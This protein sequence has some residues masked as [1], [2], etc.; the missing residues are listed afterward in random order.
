MTRFQ[1]RHAQPENFQMNSNQPISSKER[2][3]VL[4]I[5]DSWRRWLAVVVILLAGVVL[6]RA[7]RINHEGRILGPMPV[8]TN[9]VLFNTP[10]ADAIM[11]AL[12]IFPRDNAWN[13]DISRRPVLANSDSI[14]TNIT[15]ELLAGRR[16]LRAFYEMNFVLVP[17][18]QPSIPITFKLY[19]NESDPSPYPISTN[20]PV[21]GWPHETGSLT[22][23]EWQ[24]DINNAGGDR[25][26]VIIQPN[27]G[28]VW[29]TWMTRLVGTSWQAANGAKFSLNSNAQR[30]A[31]W[32]SADAAGLSMLGGLVRYDECERGMVEHA[33]RIIVKHSRQA[34]IYPASHDA[35]VPVTTDPNVPA[36]GQRL[37]LK[38]GF[39]I[40]SNWT[41]QE[42]AVLLAL[43]KYGA[44]VADNGN[45][46][47]ISVAPDL[48]FPG[49]AFDHFS[50]I[51]I[52]NFEA[53]VTTL[54]GEGPR[55]PGAPTADAGPDRRITPGGSLQLS[56]QVTYTQPSQVSWKLYSGPAPVVF[57]DSA[58][59][60]AVATFGTN[61][62]YTLM[63]SVDDGVHAVAYDAMI[64][65]VASDVRVNIYRQGGSV[66]LNWSG[67]TGP[68]DIE[69]TASTAATNWITMQTTSQTNAVL[70]MD[71][72][73]RLFRIRA[74]P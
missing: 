35:S 16:T 18:N 62:T 45:F 8:V 29:E 52:T 14:I 4:P 10:E 65:T 57:D 74:Q 64:V 36:M 37:R 32:T 11:S 27:S 61:G 67:G 49:T 42:K 7:E 38:A 12:Q 33:I 48:R 20:M 40:P 63:L 15:G 2:R 59:T 53:I 19:G 28:G 71:V 24:Q 47:S 70:P 9:A 72:S 6:V 68:F 13:E 17:T 23:S 58:R 21:E 26:S 60:N 43:K 1:T 44:I 46:F 56:G 3:S 54:A 39:V 5:I 22:L 34:Y 69:G 25:H 50:T 55:S 31:G 73:T 66:L 41:K 30:P 51:G